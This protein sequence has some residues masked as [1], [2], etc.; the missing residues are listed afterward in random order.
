MLA[1]LQFPEQLAL[2]RQDP[3]L[4]RSAVEEL[5]RYTSPVE[6]ATERY[7]L[8]DLTLQGAAIR[9][10]EQV[11]V[12]LASANHDE[13][14][15]A[16]AERLDIRRQKNKH[17]AF[18][19]GIHYCVGAPLARMEGAIAFDL[20]AQRL[21]NLRLAVAADQLKWRASMTVRGLEALP[22]KV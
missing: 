18:G 12:A 3:T 6:T 4:N 11:L 17:L 7:A 1:L 21:P 2:L 19:M 22:V 15:F 16:D 5:L 14:V 13:S 8:E 20:L 9:Q 10:G